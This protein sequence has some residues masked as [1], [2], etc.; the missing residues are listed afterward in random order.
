MYSDKKSVLQLVALLKAHDITHVVL[1]PGSRNAPLIHS[2]VTDSHFTCYSIVDERSAGFFALGVSEALRRPVAVCCTSGTAALNLAPAVAEAFYQQLPLLVITADRPLA[3]IGQMDGQT[4]PQEKMFGPLVRRSVQLPEVKDAEEEWHCNRLIN[5]AILSLDND[6]IFG[7]AHINI[8]LS[9][10]LFGFTTPT[11]PPVRVIRRPK[12]DYRISEEGQYHTRFERFTKRM[13]IVGQLPP[14]NGLSALL[15]RLRKE[16]GVV[17]LADHLSNI[18]PGETSRFDVLLRS[19]TAEEL[20]ELTPDLVITLGGHVVSKRLKQFIRSA[21]V[22]EQ[23]HVSPSGVV[24]DTFQQVTDIVRSDNETFL[25]YLAEI[26]YDTKIV[27]SE[28]T[29]TTFYST[30]TASNKPSTAFAAAWNRACA[31]VTVPDAAFSDLYAVGALMRSIPANATLQLANSHSVY[32]AQLFD[33]PSS[34]H[35]FCN[36]GTNGIEGSLS[37]AV[38]YAAATQRLTV[39]LTGDLSFF[40][41]MNGL[42]NRHLTSNLRILLN[43]NGGG[44]IFHTLPGLNSSEVLNDYIAAAHTTGAKAW[45]EQQGLRYLAARNA[46]ELQQQLPLFM[47]HESDQ[48]VLLEVFT[49]MEENREQIASYYQQQKTK[50][51]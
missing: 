19:A 5:E 10:P 6:G 41:D 34:V 8:P 18:P 33:L 43:N 44:E 27:L 15:E 11:L 50:K 31:A 32:L 49:S 38:G 28:D 39:L 16:Q 9:E 14:E 4:I 48:P 25:R 35:R 7:P 42:W 26:P 46:A 24:T 29:T 47:N 3:W 1:S 21:A 2:L 13:I 36:R 37:T 12:Q 40:Y 17:V 30:T 45:A 22:R 51:Q 20:Q 23:W